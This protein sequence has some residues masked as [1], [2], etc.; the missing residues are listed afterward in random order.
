MYSAKS[1]E[2]EVWVMPLPA[3]ESL[4]LPTPEPV[5]SV[6]ACVPVKNSTNLGHVVPVVHA[7]PTGERRLSRKTLLPDESVL[8]S[9]DIV[10]I[11]VPVAL[12]GAV[13]PPSI[14][15]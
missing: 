11:D 13:M 14:E 15:T 9:F 1:A 3:V 4:M 12:V 7:V 10:T 2:P 6:P 5:L 8:L